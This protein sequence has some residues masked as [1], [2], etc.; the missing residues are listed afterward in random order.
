MR[1]EAPQVFAENAQD[2]FQ[3]AIL[4]DEE[5][6]TS[7]SSETPIG[8]RLRR[9]PRKSSSRMKWDSPSRTTISSF[10][11]PFCIGVNIEP[12]CQALKPDS[13]PVQSA[14]VEGVVV[15]GPGISTTL[16]GRCSGEAHVT[17][18]PAG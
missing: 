16:S 1:P 4:Q 5:L 10:T 15:V 11:G 18:E 12:N 13:N 14:A 7:S 2:V 17:R 6:V 9:K 3:N 8:H